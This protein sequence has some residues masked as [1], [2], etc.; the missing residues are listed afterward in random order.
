MTRRAHP[1]PCGEHT[2][3][4]G[5]AV[6]HFGSSPPVRGAPKRVTYFRQVS[7]LIPA[8]AGSTR[9]SDRGF[10][11]R[12]AH[13]RPC[14]EHEQ[15]GGE[16]YAKQGSSPPVRGAPSPNP[17]ENLLAGLIP[18]RAGSTKPNDQHAN[19]GGAHPRPCGEHESAVRRLN[20][21]RGSSPP[22]RGALGS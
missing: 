17:V 3:A 12:W 11:V 1:R 4:I 10:S 22:V 18:A 20:A 7:G 19:F 5:N 8:R 6:T 13:P 14:G 15:V 2:G 21:K 16:A 9:R